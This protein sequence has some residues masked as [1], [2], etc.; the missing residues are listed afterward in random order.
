MQEVCK[1][2]HG[3]NHINDFYNQ[4]DEL[5]TLYNVK[6]AKPGTELI[7][8]LTKDGILQNSGLQHKLGYTWFEVWHHEGRR[9]R[10]AAA[11]QAPD[12]THWHGLYEVSR[13]FYHE[14]L[15]EVQELADH[16]GQGEK[17]KKYITDLLAKPEH[18]WIKTGGNEETMKLIKE[19][20]KLRYNQ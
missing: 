2:C 1:S 18:I 14:F 20:R 16:A 8:M 12:Y 5:V 11:M 19:E 4:F 3:I 15:P 17:Y 13:N 6:F 7:D 10:M 9:A